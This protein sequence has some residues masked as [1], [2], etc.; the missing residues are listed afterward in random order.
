MF[1]NVQAGGTN[2]DGY[3]PMKA[4]AQAAGK[5]SEIPSGKSGNRGAR[6][7]D[8]DRRL[9]KS[10][11]RSDAKKQGMG[12]NKATKSGSK[13]LK[14]HHRNDSAAAD[15]PGAPRRQKGGNKNPPRGPA[16]K[17]NNNRHTDR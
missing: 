14:R 12:A 16:R 2:D 8:S 13:K 15:G 5:R 9:P 4:A 7:D 6:Q 11:R 10:R 17:R 1:E 3:D